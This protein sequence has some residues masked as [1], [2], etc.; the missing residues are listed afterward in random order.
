MEKHVIGR[1]LLLGVLGG[2]L[3]FLYARALAEPIIARAIDYESGRDDAMADLA[4]AA[5]LTPEPGGPDIFSR[6]IQANVGIGFGM[7]LF[8]LAM[9]GIFAVVYCVAIGRVG[10]LSA[11][12]TALVVGGGLFAALYVVPFI[13]YPP[14]P[15]SIGHPETIRD[16]SGLY[17]LMVALSLIAM[18]GAVWLGKRLAPR[19]G[20]WTATLLAVAA[21][22]VVMG[23]VMALLPSL[24]QLSAN[25]EQ[26][27]H[28]AT[29]TP[30]P[31]LDKSG[32]IVYPGFPADD[33]YAFR[34]HS[35][36]AQL[37]LWATIS[38]GFASLADRLFAEP[39]QSAV[40]PR[41]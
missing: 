32:A 39:Q 23:I 13:K 9:G 25:V 10:T 41:S 24:G 37:I 26:Y 1:G 28:H 17:V 12:T 2:L 6:S 3:S 19:V 21:F 15:P 18:F 14:N 33:L 35:F 30:Q 40:L 11:R 4:R 38:V 8:G 5:G 36:V 7:L 29:E 27:G 20:T 16:R 31:L 34:F 22:V